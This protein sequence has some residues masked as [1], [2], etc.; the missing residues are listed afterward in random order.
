M[1]YNKDNYDN[2]RLTDKQE[3]FIYAIM[4]GKSQ[5]EAYRQAYPKARKWKD[6]SVDVA[7]S[8]LLNNN[9]IIIRL[10]ELKK[11]KKEK[12][13]WTRERALNEINYVLD[14]NRKDIERINDA[15]ETEINL[16]EAKILELGQQLSQAT[17]VRDM[18]RISKQMQ[19]H[20]ETIAKLKKQRRT[21]GTNVHG[22][23]EAAKIL[24]RMYGYDITKVEV[25]P[26]DTERE[27][28]KSLSVQELR[29]LAYAN[30]NK[31]EEER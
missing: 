27:N 8:Q 20:T 2:N 28:M 9:K 7:A 14:M 22:I 30:M 16:Y 6:A 21:S 26:A 4:D 3:K 17:E 19:E 23:L 25:Q 12:I 13:K 18:I 24:N 29:A 31:K 15:Y 5:R 1:A 11:I 10:E